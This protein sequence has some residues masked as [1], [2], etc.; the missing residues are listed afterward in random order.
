MGRPLAGAKADY[1]AVIRAIADFEPVL[2]VC[3]PGQARRGPQRLRRQASGV[4]VLELPIDDSWTRDNGPIFVRNAAARL[5]PSG[6]AST[7]GASRW[8]PHADDAR[9]PER[10][11][12]HLGMRL[13]EAPIILEGGSITVDGEGTVLTTEQC[14]L[15]PNRN[16]GM[17]RRPWSGTCATTSA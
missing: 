4:E 11:A 1:A 13:F 8:H 7:R 10:I 9:L 14:L 2:V 16:P 12:A 5:P 6:S 15:N 3:P 17:P